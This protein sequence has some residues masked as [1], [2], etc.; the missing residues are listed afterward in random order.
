MIILRQV[1]APREWV[2]IGVHMS[3]TRKVGCL[4]IATVYT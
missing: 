3:G 2:P 1:V 4:Q